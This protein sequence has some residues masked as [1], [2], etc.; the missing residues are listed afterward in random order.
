MKIGRID[1]ETT[2]NV[3]K[4]EGGIARNIVP[5]NTKLEIEA[6][7]LDLKKLENITSEMIKSLKSGAMV[8][9]AGLD[10]KVVRE[11]DGFEISENEIPVQVARYA[12]QR[13]NIESKVVASG[14]G[15]DVNIFNSKG[16]MAINLSSGMENI[17][18]AREFV[19]VDQLNKLAALIVEICRYVIK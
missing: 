2:S 3:G 10:Y 18:T 15:S 9:N 8:N 11:Y 5:E 16:M 6:R 17:H 19:K 7:S 14:G 4:I 13:L 1:K 12:L